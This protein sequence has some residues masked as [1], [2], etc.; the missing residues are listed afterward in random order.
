MGRQ[1]GSAEAAA[2]GQP[3]RGGGQ[4]RVRMIVRGELGRSETCFS[5]NRICEH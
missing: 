1:R 2:G 3:E 4:I 5:G